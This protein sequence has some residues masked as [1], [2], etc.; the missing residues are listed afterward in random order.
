MCGVI[1]INNIMEITLHKIYSVYMHTFKSTNKSYIGYTSLS[2][3]DR[4]KRHYKNAFVYGLENHLYRAMRKYGASDIV[5]KC[6][7]ATKDKQEALLK[8]KQLIEEYDTICKG[9]NM[10]QGGTGGKTLQEGTKEY[11]KW[12]NAKLAKVQGASNPRYCGYTDNQLIDEAAKLF[13]ENKKIYYRLWKDYAK[14]HSLPQ[15]FSGMRFGGGGWKQ[16]S[17]LLKQRLAAE[18]IKYS[19]E[20]FKY[21]KTEIHRRKIGDQSRAMLWYNDGECNTRSTP[22]KAKILK[23]KPGKI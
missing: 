14:K 10:A 21:K 20:N 13:V 22:H 3:S 11:E 23:L 1:S 19:E 6:L 9:Y 2:I 15:S 18:G 5:S 4:L 17:S 8:E 7:F 12:Y 16:F